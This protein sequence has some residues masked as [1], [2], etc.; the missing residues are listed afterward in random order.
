MQARISIAIVLLVTSTAF[1]AGKKLTDA[2]IT[3]LARLVDAK[4]TAEFQGQRARDPKARAEAKQG[5]DK[6]LAEVGWTKERYSEAMG[7]AEEIL[8]ILFNIENDKEFAADYQKQLVQ[9]H[10]ADTVARVKARK[11]ELDSSAASRRAE[12]RWRDEKKLAATGKPVTQADIQGTWMFDLELSLAHVSSTM[13]VPT[14]ALGAMR[15]ALEKNKGT[16]Y[17][18]KGNAIEVKGV[19]NEKGTYRIDGK[20]LVI[21]DGKREHR[22]QI[23]LKSADQLVFSMMGVGTVYKKK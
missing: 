2:D 20:D 6:A 1:A 17:S 12:Q 3:V 14:E 11:A 16:S 22:I 4:A 10:D 23:G 5:V 8:G 13:G 18:F 7:E 9:E 15:T 19:A 21:I